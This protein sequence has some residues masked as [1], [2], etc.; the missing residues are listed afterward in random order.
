MQA[1]VNAETPATADDSLV[2]KL[3][4]ILGT[5]IS[6]EN[7][8]ELAYEDEEYVNFR[9]PEKEYAELDY[10]AHLGDGTT[11]QL[12]MTYGD[13]VNAG[14]TSQTQW[15][16]TADAYTMG[17]SYYTGP[18]GKT[19]EVF[20]SNKSGDAIPLTETTVYQVNLGGEG[21]ETFQVYGLSKGSTVTDIVAALGNP[22]NI[23]YFYTEYDDGNTFAQLDLE[24][25]AKDG[26]LKIR[27][28]ADT[29]L[30]SSITLGIIVD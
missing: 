12:P 13:L 18:D 2:G 22:G 21:T 28:D 9:Q 30:I 1:D 4:S 8:Y 26:T 5:A 19:I 6:L 7:D 11:I 20:I 24:Y 23:T 27:L 17:S 16:D 14:W 15:V 10:T 25:N 29:G 3:Q